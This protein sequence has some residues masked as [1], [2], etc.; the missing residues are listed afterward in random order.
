MDRGNSKHG[1]RVDDEMANETRGMVQGGPVIGRAEE[2]HE[3]EPSGEDQ[4][5]DSLIP[6]LTAG[7]EGGAPAGMTPDER[8]ARS[9]L[10]RYLTR[11]AFPADRSTLTAAARASHA[12]D[13]VVAALTRLAPDQLYGT[14]SE[15]WAA[16][17]G[18]PE[19]QRF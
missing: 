8:E 17:G 11:S 4:P 15:V 6:E 14:V 10:G 16:L 9:R 3:P 13:D 1:P 12:P 5:N 2:W 18:G 7:H 19:R